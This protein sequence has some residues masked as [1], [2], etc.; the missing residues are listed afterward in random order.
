MKKAFTLFLATLFF[1]TTFSQSKG[2]YFDGTDDYVS[3]PAKAGVLTGSALTFETWLRPATGITSHNMIFYNGPILIYFYPNGANPGIIAE[4]NTSVDNSWAEYQLPAAWTNQ[5]HH[6][7]VT[8]D[9]SLIQLYLDGVAVSSLNG[10]PNLS[11]SVAMGSAG[12]LG[13]YASNLY[14]FNG[15]MD[16]LRIW[17]VARTQAQIQ[18]SMNTEIQP[19]TSGLTAYYKFNQGTADG[20]NTSIT[21]LTD[22]VSSPNNGTLFNFLKTGSTSNF[23]LGYGSISVLAVKDASFTATKIGNTV[24]LNWKGLPS[25]TASSFKVERSNDGIDF[26]ALGIINSRASAIEVAHSFTDASPL[27][28]NYY[29]IKSTDADGKIGYSKTITLAMNKLIAGLQLS[30]N[31]A[32]STIQLRLT[33]PKGSVL[34]QVK[35]LAGRTMQS[36]QVSSQGAT[37]YKSLDISSLPK[38]IYSLIAGDASTLFIKQ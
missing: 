32:S 22:A 5:W 34:L 15:T 28:T 3:I 33:A 38:G 17:N 27:A 8:Y 25:E 37:V 18:A 16:E 10:P 21:T 35:D 2:L 24:Q 1:I 7:A 26:I 14:P 29:R 11:G 4:V 19:S 20:N 9:G 6:L 12:L 36:I 31:P 13:I 30:P 23:T